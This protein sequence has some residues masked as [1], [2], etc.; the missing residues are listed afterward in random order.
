MSTPPAAASA[1]SAPCVY[2]DGGC[3]LCSREIAAYRAA[4]GGD[5]LNWVDAQD[6]PEPELGPAL[7]R[8]A[9]LARLHVR[10]PDGTLLSGAAAFVAIWQRLPAFRGLA[11]I[12]RVPGALFLMEA[13]Y[14]GFLRIRRLWRTTH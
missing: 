8:Q 3:P 7:N 11:W 13:G 14:R 12:A 2:F 6:C 10:L 5:Q 4:R 9:A 1:K